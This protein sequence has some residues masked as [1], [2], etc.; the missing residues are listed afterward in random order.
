MTS[1]R[2]L[3]T[4]VP[5]SPSASK[6][7]GVPTS[8]LPSLIQAALAA[9]PVCIEACGVRAELGG[10]EVLRGV[11]LT[12]RAGE[13]VAVVGPNGAGKSTLLK[14]LAGDLPVGGTI[15]LDG[16]PLH[17]LPPVVLA[18]R[19]A[20]LPQ[21]HHV[22]FPF[23]VSEIVAMGRAPWARTP[24]AVHD[25]AAIAEA[26][27][28]TETTALAER[29]VSW[30]SGGELARVML[31]RVL[32]QRTPVLLLDEPAAALD[33]HHQDRVLRLLA[34]RAR[35]G[36][37][38]LTILHDLTAAATHADRLVVLA[39]G[40]VRADGEPGAVLTGPL[41]SEVYGAPME[42]VPH[43]RTGAPIVLPA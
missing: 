25:G 43:P 42:V 17:S 13:L 30:L 19:R 18:R 15:T 31:A 14:A 6:V 12:V 2:P 35:G 24:Q 3:P 11:D 32:A 21:Q 8:P 9:T 16:Q 41:L 40:L 38:V 20:V 26:L 29:S 33:P 37:A 5:D 23:R 27:A 39:D 28:A 22:A 1:A 4:G 34:G 7:A 36:A 10:V